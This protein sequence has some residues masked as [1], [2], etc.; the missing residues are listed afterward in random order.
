MNFNRYKV[1]EILTTNDSPVYLGEF[2][3]IAKTFGDE[4][5][6]PD[7]QYYVQAGGDDIV[8]ELN[9]LLDLKKKANIELL[10][11]TKGNLSNSDEDLI[12]AED[13]VY[14]LV[15]AVDNNVFGILETVHSIGTRPSIGS[16]DSN[17]SIT[18]SDFVTGYGTDSLGRTYVKIADAVRKDDASAVV[19]A[20]MGTCNILEELL[21]GILDDQLRGKVKRKLAARLLNSITEEE[22]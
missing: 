19:N 14:L 20:L 16:Y 21:A 22:E 15:G 13:S 18:T 3:P 2:A 1:T 7:S 17:V 9:G 6:Q 4:T 8:C 12:S 10:K 5:A 11:E